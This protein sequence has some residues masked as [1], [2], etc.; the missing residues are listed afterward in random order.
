MHDADALK[1]FL[2]EHGLTN[3]ELDKQVCSLALPDGPQR[4]DEL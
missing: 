4:L 1:A 3:T 2:I